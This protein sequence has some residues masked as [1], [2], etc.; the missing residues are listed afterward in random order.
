MRFVSPLPLSPQAHHDHDQAEVL[1][2]V[3]PAAHPPLKAAET[4]GMSTSQASRNGIL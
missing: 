2:C 1:Q 3:P 4:E